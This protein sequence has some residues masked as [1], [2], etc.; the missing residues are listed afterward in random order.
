MSVTVL[1]TS[2]AFILMDFSPLNR[3]EDKISDRI[4]DENGLI[5]IKLFREKW[6]DLGPFENSTWI[7]WFWTALWT[8]SLMPHLL[9]NNTYNIGKLRLSTIVLLYEHDVQ[10]IGQDPNS[11]CRQ[12]YQYPS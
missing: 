5:M 11:L 2:Y 12:V 7:Y 6:V 9:S 3:P 10:R 1:F 4:L 8:F